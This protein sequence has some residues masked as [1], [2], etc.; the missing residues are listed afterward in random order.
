MKMNKILVGL[1]VCIAL[2]G[3]APQKTETE[4]QTE[5]ATELITEMITET[6]GPTVSEYIEHVKNE[7][8]NKGFLLAYPDD[9]EWNV[10]E[11]DGFIS[12]SVTAN[13]AGKK[14]IV[15]AW[16]EKDNSV[17]HYL[18]ENSGVLIDDGVIE[19]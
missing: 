5:K 17:I 6:K 19:D 8:S 15:T 4:K 12:L 2:N 10:Y 13:K 16:I 3:C 7:V 14:D 1:I 11:V 9:N 18:D